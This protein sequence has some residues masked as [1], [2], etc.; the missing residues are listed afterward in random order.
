MYFNVHTH[1][2]GL[3]IYNFRIGF[4]EEPPPKFQ[5]FS[6]GIHPWDLN[7]IDLEKAYHDLEAYL[8]WPNCVA[9][10]ELGLDKICGTDLDLQ[11]E[12]FQKQI[13]IAMQYQKKVLII[14]SV[15]A[16][17]EIISSKKNNDPSLK[18]ILH[19]FN[20]GKELIAQLSRNGFYFSIGHLLL[21]PNSKIAHHI[22]NVPLERL[23]LESDES[24][25]GM[26]QIYKEASR[27]YKI[28]E[29]SFVREIEKNR[30]YIFSK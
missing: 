14:H 15:K 25:V 16:F 17:Q 7:H 11:Q 28:E 27:K 10:G 19:G 13:D 6:V 23:F 26:E 29:S 21:N 12:V 9:L 5:E 24:E 18:W 30:S 4:I 20:G 2:R 3:G 1:Q 8:Q 22:S